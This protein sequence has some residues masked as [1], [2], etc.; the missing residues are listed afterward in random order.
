MYRTTCLDVIIRFLCARCCGV[1]DWR[2]RYRRGVV[3]RLRYS[4]IELLFFP[5]LISPFTHRPFWSSLALFLPLPAPKNPTPAHPHG[6]IIPLG[7]SRPFVAA[8]TRN[9]PETARDPAVVAAPLPE[10]RLPGP[11]YVPSPVLLRFPSPPLPKTALA[12]SLVYPLSFTPC[13]TPRQHTPPSL[14][15]TMF[16][17]PIHFPQAKTALPTAGISPLTPKKNIRIVRAEPR[18]LHTARFLTRRCR[19]RGQHVSSS[20]SSSSSSP[21]HPHPPHPHPH[22]PPLPRPRPTPGPAQREG[23]RQAWNANPGRPWRKKINVP[24]RR[25]RR[26]AAGGS[27]CYRN[28]TA[29][30]GSEGWMGGGRGMLVRGRGWGRGMLGRGWERGVGVREMVG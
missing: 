17:F 5:H 6:L 25:T 23:D 12:G 4:D 29:R 7:H 19:R 26:N 14:P 21:A 24:V 2:L 10:Y 9:L 27:A 3:Q 11:T 20:S 8:S 28:R 13:F 15:G 30:S 18:A 22:P 1:G 16:F